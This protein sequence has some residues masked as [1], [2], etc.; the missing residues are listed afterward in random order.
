MKKSQKSNIKLEEQFH[1]GSL[2]LRK[3]VV[4][5]FETEYWDGMTF[6]AL[7]IEL[8]SRVKF[9]R[10]IRVALDDSTV[11]L[12]SKEELEAFWVRV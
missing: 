3:I 1:I 2:W 8:K 10:Y 12:L 4:K 11:F 6:C 5:G 7:I 9:E